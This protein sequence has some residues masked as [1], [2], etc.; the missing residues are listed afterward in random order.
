MSKNYGFET[1]KTCLKKYKHNILL[2]YCDLSIIIHYNLYN[3]YLY[4]FVFLDIIQQTC[5]MI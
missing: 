5:C 4:V 1:N 3:I 2:L